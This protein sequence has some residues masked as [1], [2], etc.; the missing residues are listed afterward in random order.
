MNGVHGHVVSAVQL[1]AV[2]YNSVQE[3][4]AVLFVQY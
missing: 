3:P 1:V 4:V 2:E